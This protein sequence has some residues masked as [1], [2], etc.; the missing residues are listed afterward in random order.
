MMPEVYVSTDI[1]ADGPMPGRHSMLSFGS[2]AVAED[3][4]EVGAFEVNLEVLPGAESDPDTMA[5]WKTQPEAWAAHRRALVPA[6]EAMPRYAAW[7]EGLPGTPVFVAYPVGYDFPYVQYYLHH[8]A[9]RSPF[10]F[11]CLDLKTLG[12][13]LLPGTL[14]GTSKKTMPKDWFDPELP[15]THV[16]IDDAREHAALLRSMLAVRAQRLG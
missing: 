1:E 7:L 3:G 15:H 9:G 10:N 5:W 11:R 4:T 14:R 16:A 13:A 2:V 6:A 8:F 12:F